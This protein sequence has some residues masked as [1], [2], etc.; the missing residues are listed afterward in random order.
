MTSK[1]PSLLLVTKANDLI[2]ASY[3]LTLQEQRLL[4]A[5][6]ARTLI[7]RG[8][9]GQG[10]RLLDAAVRRRP[11]NLTIQTELSAAVQELSWQL[12]SGDGR[13]RISPA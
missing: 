2:S 9:L 7:D 6:I 10:I 12:S 8:E 5:A 4:L 11:A 3:R 1:E 13:P